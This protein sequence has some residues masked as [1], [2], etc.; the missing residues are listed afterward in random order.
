MHGACS[1]TEALNAS[2][3]GGPA[4]G[5]AALPSRTTLQPICAHGPCA[6]PAAH[7]RMGPY[8]PAAHVFMICHM[9]CVARRRACV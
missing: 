3:G 5:L 2:K 8:H 6:H 4:E 1:C 9:S 7:V